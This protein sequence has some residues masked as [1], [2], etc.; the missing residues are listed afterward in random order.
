MQCIQIRLPITLSL[1]IP[2]FG[3]NSGNLT[4]V[5]NE[6]VADGYKETLKQKLTEADQLFI[7]NKYEDVV[8]L[9]EEFKVNFNNIISKLHFVAFLTPRPSV[10]VW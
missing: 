1:A 9:L 2:F 8:H 7:V 5:D 10:N 4:K 3:Y 6:P